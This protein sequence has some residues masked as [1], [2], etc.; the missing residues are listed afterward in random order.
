[1]MNV[2][3]NLIKYSLICLFLSVTI[4]STTNATLNYTL[5][6]RSDLVYRLIPHD[7]FY[8]SNK[9]F[10][11]KVLYKQPKLKLYLDPQF[12][13]FSAKLIGSNDIF[14]FYL[15]QAYLRLNL[16][17][18]GTVSIGKIKIKPEGMGTGSD[19]GES[20]ES[21]LYKAIKC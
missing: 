20:Q 15:P 16:D 14:R 11:L 9:D 13:W 21:K 17:P 5:Q 2:M 12:T 19:Y 3:K 4:T 10:S 8:A 1:M 18:L 6:G 7:S